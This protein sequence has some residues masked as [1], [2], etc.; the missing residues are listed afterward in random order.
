MDTYPKGS[1]WRRWDLHIHTPKSI[2]Q[3]YGG[4]SKT[5]WDAFI[6]KI[7]SLPPEIKVIS[8]TDYLFC[9]GYE[10]LLKRKSEI[11]NIELIIPNIEFRLNTFSGTVNNTKRHNFHVLF[12]PSVSVQDIR[13]QLLNC[14]SNGYKIQDKSVWQQTP[15]IRSLQDLGKQIKAAAPSENTVHSKSDLE[16]GFDNITYERDD[17]EKL[18]EKTP[19]KG[20]FVTAIGYSEWDQSRWDQSAAEKRTLI[21]EADFCLTN[22]D[23]PS[24]ISQHRDNLV[25]NKLNSLILHSSDAH[26]L[27]R[28]GETM[29]WVKADPTF[30]GL[31]QVLNEQDAR[32]F[33][34][35]APPNYKHSHQVISKIEI[36]NS[37]NWFGNNF[38]LDLNRDLVAVIGGRGSGK[39]ALV[40]MIAYGA[41]SFD[42][43]EG[44]F[45]KKASQHKESIKGVRVC[46]VWEDGTKTCFNVGELT[47]DMGLVR[48][49]PQKAIEQLCDSKNTQELQSQIENVI[50][51]SLP[52]T[53]KLGASNFVELIREILSIS[54]EEK[55]RIVR[56]IQD[57]N[58]TLQLLRNSVIELPVKN[59]KLEED[60][61][62]L[63]KLKTSLPVLPKEDAKGQEELAKLYEQ[64]RIFE[65]KIVA[66]KGELKTVAEIRAKVRQFKRQALEFETSILEQ[67]KI[68]GI[69][70]EVLF[71]V[72]I[73]S[74]LI[75]ETLVKK[76][77]EVQGS[78]DNL[79]SGDK[80]INAAILSLKEE[81][82]LSANMDAIELEIEQ[83]VKTTKA[84]ETEKIKYQKQKESIVALEKKISSSEKEIQRINSE[85]IPFIARNET[86]RLSQYSAYFNLL[87]QEKQ[88]IE[89]L[90]RP[91]QD[92]LLQGTDTDKRLNFEAKIVYS[93]EQHL[94]QG[95][96]IIDRSRKGNFREVDTLKN[97]LKD[98]A[99]TFTRSEFSETE[100]ESGIN[101]ILQKF[102]DDEEGP[103]FEIKDQLREIYN[104]ED[105]DNW[106]FDPTHFSVTSSLSFDGT[107]LHLLSPGQKGIV[108]LMLYLE[109]DK[110]DTRPLLIDQPEDNLDS[111][112]VYNDLIYFFRDRKQYRQIIMV[113][114]N[115]NLVVNTD[116]EQIIVA[117][118]SGG[119]VPRLQYTSGSLE[120]QVK[121]DL[122]LGAENLTDGIIEHVCNI[123]EGGDKAVDGRVKKY[124]ISKKNFK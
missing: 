18:L 45:I 76:E 16:V 88:E 20:R 97:A 19:F 2:I 22:L 8:I 12:D 41:G 26:Q 30:A 92:S 24:I 38:E 1:E 14:L 37:N 23:D 58:K 31:M 118:Y 68:I 3:N 43:S 40:E 98:L 79:K 116:S 59:T 99:L 96:Q 120:D 55:N 32:V 74:E 110:S 47:E 9:D 122:T 6:K 11:P 52:E 39:S 90:Y 102:T 33:I 57:L 75:E 86:E 35:I 34:G 84:F 113:S 62:Q 82:M 65:E 21:N 4:D 115:P 87:K 112:S 25:E 91:L 73:K 66:F 107:D 78:L 124:K 101:G 111:L 61:N 70:D 51:Q 71:K 7:A 48:Y 94:N 27:D 10:E 53:E 44:S 109:I 72:D 77:T 105:F 28:V 50:F 123:L 46:L 103:K 95:L 121:G 117:N 108:L 100:I 36:Q 42:T 60:K 63:Q 80:K 104:S 106:L 83:K 85:T 56:I 69:T 13:D 64:K 119:R 49:L 15:T 67:S 29:L 54:Q 5:V 89:K 17:I 81:E 93:A 114:H